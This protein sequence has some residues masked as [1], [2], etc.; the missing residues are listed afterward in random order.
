MMTKP[1]IRPVRWRPPPSTPLPEPD[2]K[3]AV[4]IVGLPGH[5]PE[6]VVARL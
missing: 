6:D 5:A 4:V 1:P 2:L 3:S